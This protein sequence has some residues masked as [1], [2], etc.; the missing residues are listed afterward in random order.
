M[1]C[2]IHPIPSH[3]IASKRDYLSRERE[4]ERERSLDTHSTHPFREPNLKE[5]QRRSGGMI[6]SGAA[7]KVG[8]P[9]GRVGDLKK[10]NEDGIEI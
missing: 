10:E 6:R 1:V 3:P 4:R 5:G 7:I 2:R 9:A 8:K